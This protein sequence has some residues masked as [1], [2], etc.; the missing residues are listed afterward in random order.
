[1][2][3]NKTNVPFVNEVEEFNEAMNKPNFYTPNIP[4]EEWQWKFVYDFI[5]EELEEYKEA[6]I[7]GDIVGVADAL[8]DIMYVLCNGIMLHGMKDKI[9]EV[10]AEI[11]RSNMSKMCLTEEDASKTVAERMAKLQVNCHYEKVNN[12]WV[13]YRSDD[14]KVMKS[15]TYTPPN[16]SQFFEEK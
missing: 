15:I 11:Q 2:A 16:L 6:C 13:V 1:M 14:M 10:Y 3:I 5:L 4:L 12:H 7:E 8:G 9:Q